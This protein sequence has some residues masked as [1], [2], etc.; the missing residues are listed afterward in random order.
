[1]LGPRIHEKCL[2][3]AVRD[4]CV[5]K[6][7][8]PICAITTSRATVLM[9]RLHELCLAFWNDRVFDRNQHWSPVKVGCSLSDDNR[10][11]PM[12]PWTQIRSRLRKF[13]EEHE[14]HAPNCANSGINKSD[15]DA[16]SLSYRAPSSAPQSEAPLINQD[17]DC[18][19]SCSYPVR[20]K[21]LNQSVDQRNESYPGRTAD[22]HHGGECAQSV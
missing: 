12:V 17:E 11:A 6:Y 9:N 14:H 10:H 21:V 13:C 4:C 18:K 16:C 20:G 2:Q 19:Y 7:S 5:T 15:S 8:P 3:I 1:M 22:E